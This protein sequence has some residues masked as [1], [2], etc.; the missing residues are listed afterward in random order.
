MAELRT[1]VTLICLLFVVGGASFN[2]AE[3]DTAPGRCRATPG[4]EDGSADA[5][6]CDESEVPDLSLMQFR[7]AGKVERHLAQTEQKSKSHVDA[8]DAQYNFIQD[9]VK[10]HSTGEAL[11]AEIGPMLTSIWQ[12]ARDVQTKLQEEHD[13]WAEEVDRKKTRFSTCDSEFEANHTAAETELGAPTDV[14]FGV[15]CERA[16]DLAE[17]LIDNAG[18]ENVLKCRKADLDK[19]KDDLDTFMRGDHCDACNNNDWESGTGTR[20]EQMT[21]WLLGKQGSCAE[22]YDTQLTTFED[23]HS[24]YVAAN[25]TYNEQEAKCT[26]LEGDVTSATMVAFTLQCATTQKKCAHIARVEEVCAVRDECYHGATTAWTQLKGDETTGQVRDWQDRTSA[27]LAAQKI[28]CILK[29]FTIGGKRVKD[30][31]DDPTG[32]VEV[33]PSKGDDFD[34]IANLATCSPKAGK[35]WTYPN[36]KKL[37]MEE[38][39]DWTPPTA[40]ACPTPAEFCT[41]N[42]WEPKCPTWD[43]DGGHTPQYTQESLT[44]GECDLVRSDEQVSRDATTARAY[45]KNCNQCSHYE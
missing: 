15:F 45:E 10:K 9:L 41:D 21:A 35:S 19:A 1:K 18:C 7:G 37:D 33:D 39:L 8:L 30:A 2:V 3:A 13:V 23:L 6:D 24:K 42:G 36:C 5:T 44:P 22:H 43:E 20:V 40:P 27:F 38:M 28:K 25:T 26:A 32:A 31:R 34:C 17:T 11:P 4:S 16:K 29:I 12:D 14:T